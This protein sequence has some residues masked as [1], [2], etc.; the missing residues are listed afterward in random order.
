MQRHFQRTV[1][2]NV[3]H[4]GLERHV[5]GVALRRA[6][7]V[8][9]GLGN[10][11]LALRAAEALLHVPG[12]QAQAECAWVGVTDVLAGHAHHPAGQVEGVAAAVDHA[13]VPVEGRI[14]VGAAHRFVQGGNLVV[15]GFAA[16]V[17][18][19]TAVAQQVLQQ[20]DTDLTTVVGKVGSVFQEVEQASAIA[21]RGSHQ[22][23]ETL[24]RQ[25]QLALAQSLVLVQ[26]TRHQLA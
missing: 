19:A 11:Q 16:L 6:G 12:R 25:A 21:V 4:R 1:L 9:H 7:Q 26:R 22:D 24:V 14:R 13:C 3:A 8:D 10:R 15:E 2:R 20:F 17:E 18:T 23:R 5:D